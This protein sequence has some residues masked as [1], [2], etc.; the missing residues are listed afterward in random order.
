M[1]QGDIWM[2]ST[3]QGLPEKMTLILRFPLQS[4]QGRES[5]LAR[6]SIPESLF[7]GLHIL[8]TDDDDVNRTVTKKQLEK[9]GCQVTAVSSGFECLSALSHA[10]CS[11]KVVFLDLYLSDMDGFEV[12]TRI[13]KFRSRNWPLIIALTASTEEQLAGK[14]LQSGMNGVVQKPAVLQTLADEMQRVLNRVGG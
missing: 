7:R 10:D 3:S 13:R 14:C 8:L 4:I 12:A 2:A 1:M 5:M 9:L 6:R 11:F